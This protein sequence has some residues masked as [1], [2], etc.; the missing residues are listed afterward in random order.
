MLKF[1]NRQILQIILCTALLIL[2]VHNYLNFRKLYSL[3]AIKNDHVNQQNL[4]SLNDD[5]SVSSN[6]KAYYQRQNATFVT[7]ARNSDI[8]SIGQSIYDVESRFNHKYHYDWVFFNEEP[9]TPEFIKYTSQL[10][11]GRTFYETVPKKFWSYPDHINQTKAAESRASMVEK[12]II[13]AGSESY[14]HMCRFESG[15]FWQM[16]I[17]NNYRYYWRVE[18]DISISCDIEEDLFKVMADNQYK[19]GFTIA[20]YEYH[21]TIPTL[22]DT[23]MEFIKANPKYVHPNNLLD[24]ISDNKGQTYNLCHFWSNFEIADLDFWRSSAYREYFDY[25]DKQGGFFYERWGDAPVHSIA[26]SLFLNS[27]EI[28]YFGQ[29][30]YTHSPYTNC[31]TDLNFHSSHRCTCNPN[32]SFTFDGYSCASKYFTVQ[33]IDGKS[34]GS[35]L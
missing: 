28:K 35:Y 24:F 16:P 12:K 10:I 7:L 2:L 27:S 13:Y 8:Y 6:E 20:M 15:F 34:Y 31:P 19:Y 33:G 4:Q 23:T 3:E 11:S 18:P 17:M 30:G 14:R 26:A 32:K 21:A 9:F 22:W 5:L 29:I 1:A 25:L